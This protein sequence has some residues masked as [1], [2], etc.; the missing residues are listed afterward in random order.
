MSQVHIS[1]TFGSIR[2]AKRFEEDLRMALQYEPSYADGDIWV[3][4]AILSKT[5]RISYPAFSDMWVIPP[6][7]QDILRHYIF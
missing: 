5:V 2:Q 7:T 4:R 1:R 3:D 6:Q